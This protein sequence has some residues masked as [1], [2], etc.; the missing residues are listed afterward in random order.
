MNRSKKQ[1]KPQTQQNH[2]NNKTFWSSRCFRDLKHKWLKV[3]QIRQFFIV[4]FVYDGHRSIG[5]QATPRS[6]I[7]QTAFT[8]S[9]CHFTQSFS[10]LLQ[11]AP[12]LHQK[13]HSRPDWIVGQRSFYDP[14]RTHKSHDFV[15][16][17]PPHWLLLPISAGQILPS[18]TGEDIN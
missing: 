11:A 13:T 2:N 5:F 9:T 10:R 3:V 17:F 12:A 7:S 6:V 8:R 4:T 15:L 18:P 16:V 1:I 14:G